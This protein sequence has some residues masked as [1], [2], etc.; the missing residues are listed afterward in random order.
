ME[1]AV[2]SLRAEVALECMNPRWNDSLI[3]IL[4]WKMTDEVCKIAPYPLRC[5]TSLSFSL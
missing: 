1:E 2:Q 5:P 3:M 4:I